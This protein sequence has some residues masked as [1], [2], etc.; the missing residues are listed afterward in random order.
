MYERNSQFPG[1]RATVSVWR[2]MPFVG[3]VDLLQRR[4]L[5]FN[6]LERLAD[7]YEGF[8]S[9]E[10]RPVLEWK[11]PKAVIKAAERFSRRNYCVNCWHENDGESAAMWAVYSASDGIDDTVPGGSRLKAK[12]AWQA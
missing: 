11:V 1:P 12:L 4:K 7:P 5:F 3:L 10:I 9:P 6:R 8:Y 2:Y